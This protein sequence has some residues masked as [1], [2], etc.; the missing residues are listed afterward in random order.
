MRESRKDQSTSDSDSDKEILTTEIKKEESQ[1]LSV[2]FFDP[3]QASYR[4]V[5]LYK[6]SCAA[7]S[8]AMLFSMLL[9]GQVTDKEMLDI[10]ELSIYPKIWTESGGVAD[11]NKSL[12]YIKQFIE[13]KDIQRLSAKEAIKLAP[14]PNFIYFVI[15]NATTYRGQIPHATLAIANDN[16]FHYIEMRA[17]VNTA[18]ALEFYDLDHGYVLQV[19]LLAF[20]KEKI[21]DAYEQY[22]IDIAKCI[23]DH[24]IADLFSFSLLGKIV[25]DYTPPVLIDHISDILHEILK[26]KNVSFF[27]YADNIISLLST[28]PEKKLEV[29]RF[30]FEN[31]EKVLID[32][33]SILLAINNFPNKKIE[34]E[35]YFIKWMKKILDS[36][37]TVYYAKQL[38]P[39]LEKIIL[40]YF[41]ENMDNIL[42]RDMFF[43]YDAAELFPERINEIN[44]FLIKKLPSPLQQQSVFAEKEFKAI[45]D[46][47]KQQD[48]TNLNRKKS[49]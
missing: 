12:D 29:E 25:R 14:D 44:R 16:Q 49:I 15:D 40:Q 34:I 42:S 19:N 30:V 18:K 3:K 35:N 2:D 8:C 10:F 45:P 9:K 33:K 26:N 4:K 20:N 21:K 47:D 37:A 32:F 46:A 1:T 17:G 28:F 24:Y 11:V 5:Q 22:K 38:F 41:D 7:Y 23:G 27:E 43:I 39:H 13:E 48:M 31:I 6:R 36:P